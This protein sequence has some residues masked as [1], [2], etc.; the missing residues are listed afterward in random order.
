MKERLKKA[1]KWLRKNVLNKEMF[2][3][4]LIAEVIFWSPCIITGIMALLINPWYWGAFGAIIAFWAGP[5][6]PAVPLQFGFAIALKKLWDRLRKKQRVNSTVEGV[7][8]S[9]EVGGSTP[10][11]ATKSRKGKEESAAQ[12]DSSKEKGC[13]GEAE[14]QDFPFPQGKAETRRRNG[15]GTEV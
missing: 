7:G 8:H 10:S 6:T 4:V 1:W 15:K 13:L 12:A 14:I 3:F 5:L 11:P 9:H 2:I